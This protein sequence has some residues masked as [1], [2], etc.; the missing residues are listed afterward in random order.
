M[1]TLAAGVLADAEPK[2]FWL[3]RPD[4]PEP[5][6]RLVGDAEADLVVVGGGFTGLWAAVQ[7][8]EADLGRDVVLLEAEQ[9]AEGATG[10]NGGFCSASLTHGLA[11]GLAR[12][13]DELPALLRLGGA[14]LDAIES[15][16]D[17]YGIDCGLERT[18]ELTVAVRPWQVEELAG[19]RRQAER[20]GLGWR[21]LDGE[22]VRAEVASP[23]YLAGLEDSTGCALVDPA[24]LA[25]GLR[26]VAQRLG[27][28]LH[29]RTPA[30][31]LS[32]A[33]AA[34]RVSTPYG[35]VSARQVLLATGVSR[36][37]LR[38]VA[39]RI[40]PVWDYALMTEPLSAVQRS[41][42][43]WRRRQGLADAGN[44]FH[45]YRLTPDDRLLFGG[46]DAVYAWRGSTDPRLA[47]RPETFAL[48]A[49][50][51]LETFPQLEGVRAT[52]A[53][54]GVIDTCARFSPFWGTALGGRV[55]YVAGYTGLG[56]GASHFGAATALDLLDG[57][58]TERTRLRMVQTRPVPFPPEPL[59]W[60][61][62]QLTRRALAR[63][64]ATDGRRG[65]WLRALDAMG[66][67]FDS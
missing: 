2:P 3:D 20:L 44:Q 45:Y 43:A 38:R 11:N 50:H 18:G 57:R 24:R 19:L 48:L 23:T 66:L 46:Y 36:P 33:G 8:L 29:E 32:R 4:R 9:V 63:A 14:T 31:A 60:A 53:W 39:T 40:V 25:W 28:R 62:I 56:V 17:R 61:G 54:G 64:D 22:R 10:R 7:A 13:A 37:L 1:T 67:G 21:W 30:L 49:Q 34:V 6:P 15:A 58:N 59:R 16:V 26:D 65:P 55:A 51:L 12:F 47:Q 27:V 41:E 42:L 52:H 5:A 35:A